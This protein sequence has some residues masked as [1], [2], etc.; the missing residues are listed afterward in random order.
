MSWVMPKRV[1][2]ARRSDW[3][4]HGWGQQARQLQD[5]F[6]GK[7]WLAKGVVGL[8]QRWHEQEG[9]WGLGSAAG[10]WLGWVQLEQLQLGRWLHV[11]AGELQLLSAGHARWAT[12][13]LER[14]S[15]YVDTRPA[16]RWKGP[17]SEGW[18]RDTSLGQAQQSGGG[19]AVH[20]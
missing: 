9:A 4:V 1:E 12:R 14:G 20:R 16:S 6:S 10:D 19:P 3:Q 8:A 5:A 2:G 11:T 15:M 13:A 7:G 17:R 18:S